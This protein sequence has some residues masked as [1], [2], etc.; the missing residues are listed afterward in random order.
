MLAKRFFQISGLDG[1]RNQPRIARAIQPNRGECTEDDDDVGRELCPKAKSSRGAP[2]HSPLSHPCGRISI[3][4]G[5]S[6]RIQQVWTTLTRPW[7]C[8]DPS[9]MP[10]IA[11]PQSTKAMHP[12]HNSSSSTL[13]NT[14]AE[15]WTPRATCVLSF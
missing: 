3:G 10:D 8:V 12:L 2:P 15:T 13:F 6:S 7:A 14:L 5:G 9:R 4:L 11:P 1:P